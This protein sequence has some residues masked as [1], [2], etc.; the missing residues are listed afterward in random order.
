MLA[1]SSRHCLRHGWAHEL[2]AT[3][4]CCCCLSLPSAAQ[5]QQPVLEL[6]LVSSTAWL[7]VQFFNVPQAGGQ[8]LVMNSYFVCTV[9]PVTGGHAFFNHCK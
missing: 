7:A 8:F 2:A 4:A 5:Q 1:G 9:R 3:C 6:E